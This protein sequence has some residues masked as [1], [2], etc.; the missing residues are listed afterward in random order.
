MKGYTHIDGVAAKAEC[1]KELSRD[2][3]CKIEWKYVVS[4]PTE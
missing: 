2:Q 1:E 3:K 4:E